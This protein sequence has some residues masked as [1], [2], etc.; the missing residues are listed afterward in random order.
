MV[1]NNFTGGVSQKLT[2]ELY[3]SGEFT[4]KVHSE[5]IFI[6]VLNIFL[7][8]TAFLGNTLILVALPKVSSLHLPSKVLFGSL[9]TTDIC[10]G[11]IVEPTSVVHWMYAVKQKWNICYYATAANF[12]ISN[13]LCSVS[14]AI[15]TAISVDRLLALS[16]GLRYRNF[17]TFRRTLVAVI[18]IWVLSFLIT[19]GNFW[20]LRIR[21]W[22]YH[23]GICVCLVTSVF[24]Y[25][26]IFLTLRRKQIKAKNQM[27]QTQPSQAIPL[28]IARYRKAVNSAMWVQVTLVVCYLPFAVVAALTPQRGMP[29]SIY[30]ARQYT[31][32]V[33]YLNSTL[34]PLLYCWRI[35]EVKRGV[36][37]TIRRFCSLKLSYALPQVE[38]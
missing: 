38:Q 35:R 19:A 9:A 1:L 26:K 16:L 15:S 30:L 34:N 12:I 11:V 24:A 5:L 2:T 10:V 18:S 14:L 25:T 23:L 17:V 4:G 29:L 27:S 36:K 8:I 22:F 13:T 7:S 33:V 31:G 32:T 28:N 20:D 21:L 37:D 6:S 3:C